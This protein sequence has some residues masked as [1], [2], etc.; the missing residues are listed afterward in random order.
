MKTIPS[1]SQCQYPKHKHWFGLAHRHTTSFVAINMSTDCSAVG[2]PAQHLCLDV[3]PHFC[4]CTLR[5][6]WSWKEENSP[7]LWAQKP[8]CYVKHIKQCVLKRATKFIVPC[9]IMVFKS[10]RCT[11]LNWTQPQATLFEFEVNL[12]LWTGQET[13][14]TSHFK[15]FYG[16]SHQLP[17]TA[18]ISDM[19]Y[20]KNCAETQPFA[21]TT[22]PACLHWICHQWIT[23]FMREEKIL[24]HLWGARR[25]GKPPCSN[26]AA[27]SRKET[28]CE[29]QGVNTGSS[30][31]G[32]CSLGTLPGNLHLSYLPHSSSCLT[33]LGGQVCCV[34]DLDP[35]L[36]Y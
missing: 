22:S 11:K 1:I 26:K 5:I 16:C 12:A 17:L 18:P 20:T 10:W 32:W 25:E 24:S 35:G 29:H 13:S 14:K 7:W 4:P 28:G 8:A 3:T 34:Q 30:G 21:C 9:N 31:R 15:W 23:G 2:W 36:W 33:L 27:P 19:T 6:K